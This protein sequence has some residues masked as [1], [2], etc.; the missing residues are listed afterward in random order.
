MAKKLNINITTEVE[1]QL[2]ATSAMIG[3][4][5][6]ISVDENSISH[7][8]EAFSFGDTET[9]VSSSGSDIRLA[10]EN[11][12]FEG[13]AVKKQGESTFAVLTSDDVTAD[14][15]VDSNKVVTSSGVYSHV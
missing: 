10:A 4:T 2:K 14:V 7:I 11:I 12:V 3:G 15:E 1:G 8:G 5:L 13:A 9:L 6:G